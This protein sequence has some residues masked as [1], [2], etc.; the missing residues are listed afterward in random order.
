M[1]STRCESADAV[2]AHWLKIKALED[3]HRGR[4]RD[5]TKPYLEKIGVPCPKCGKEV[6]RK[7]TIFACYLSCKLLG[8]NPFNQP[9]VEGYKGY[10]FQNLGK[11]GVN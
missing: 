7:K 11:P 8:V 3:R 5:R 6:V 2:R 4:G 10:M 1:P 9:G